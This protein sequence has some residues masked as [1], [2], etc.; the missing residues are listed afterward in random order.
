MSLMYQP[1]RE[2]VDVAIRN[3]PSVL[4]PEGRGPMYVFKEA[5][6]SCLRSLPYDR[7]A[8]QTLRSLPKCCIYLLLSC[9]RVVALV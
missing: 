4:R 8:L 9:G 5:T 2:R 1:R 7:D 3:L 6:F